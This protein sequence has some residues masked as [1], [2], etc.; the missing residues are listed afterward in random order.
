[1]KN[2]KNELAKIWALATGWESR[3]EVPE[4]ER[5]M[6]LEW[7][8][9]VYEQIRFYQVDPLSQERPV[10]DATPPPSVKT[11]GNNEEEFSSH[12]GLKPDDM[13]P[14]AEP[15]PAR[16][17]EPE[18]WVE[19]EVRA[20]QADYAPQETTTQV[21]PE[22]EEPVMIAPKRV[23][24]EAIRALYGNDVPEPEAEPK[25]QVEKVEVEDE[26]IPA[27]E[28]IPTPAPEEPAMPTI[29]GDAMA[30]GHKSLGDSFHGTKRDVA[31]QITVDKTTLKRAIGIN[32]RFLMIRDMFGGDAAAFD[33]TVTKLDSFTELDEAIIWI[34]DNFDWNAD[35]KGA[36]QLVDLLQRKLAQ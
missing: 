33:R 18:P 2:I 7:L 8:R 36:A 31:S 10:N 9:E 3:D 34:H 5:E 27:H 35:S 32:D 14:E 30:A 25:V 4:I 11:D 12:I 22:T 1:M 24:P 20:A 6:A 21:E 23:A 13:G 26:P 28:T 17:A 15:M 19:S 16:E 29:L